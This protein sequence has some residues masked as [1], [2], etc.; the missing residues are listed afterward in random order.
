[1]IEIDALTK[2]YGGKLAVDELTFRVRPGRVTGFLGPNGAGK[3]TTMRQ[4]LGLDAPTRGRATVQG[5][6][7]RELEVPLSKVGSLLDADAAH[8]GR[9]AFNHLLYL[10]KSNRLPRRRVTEVLEMV[11]LDGVAGS[12]VGSFSLGMRQRLGIAAAMIGDPEVLILDEPMNGLD[13][14]GIRWVR[15]L[16]KDVAAEGRTV[17][18]SSHLMAEM[19]LVADHLI[20]IGRGRLIADSSMH[21]FIKA[22]SEGFTFVRSPNS[23]MLRS[24]LEAKG[25]R[26]QF[27]PEGGW[28]VSGLDAAAIGDAAAE[29]GIT[30]HELTPRNST[31]EEVYTRMT[32]TSVDYLGLES[33]EPAPLLTGKR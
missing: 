32:Q 7:Y 29:E 6:L 8:K 26:V 16:M 9:S 15:T 23:D 11:G 28:R 33:A 5:K 25:G 18:V 12:R 22:N 30:L 27:D 19:E 24:A 1:M 21:Q 20:V 17:F 3:S 2:S 31:L 4:I 14:Q 10:A 13:T